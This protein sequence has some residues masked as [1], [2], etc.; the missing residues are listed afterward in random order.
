METTFTYFGIAVIVGVIIVW[1][2]VYIN[3]RGNQ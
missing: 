1:G 3:T 2:L